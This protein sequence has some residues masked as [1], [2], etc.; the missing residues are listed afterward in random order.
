MDILKSKYYDI[1]TNDKNVCKTEYRNLCKKYHPDVSSAKNSKEIFQHITSL[2]DEAMKKIDSNNWESNNQFEFLTDKSKI[3]VNFLIKIETELCTKYICKNSILYFFEK[4]NKL[5]F[6][7]MI[8]KIK[9]IE[10]YFLLNKELA[11]QYESYFPKILDI[12]ENQDFNIVAIK[13][14]NNSIDLKTLVSKNIPIEPPHV[15]W[16]ISRL[17]GLQMVLA[18]MGIEYNDFSINSIY[19]DVK[20]HDVFLYDGFWYSTKLNEKLIALEKSVYES[21]TLIDKTNKTSS[22]SSNIESI[23]QIG[24]ILLTNGNPNGF[25]YINIPKEIKK[26]FMKGSSND[27]LKEFQ[28]WDKSIDSIGKRVFVKFNVDVENIYEGE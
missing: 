24:K 15:Y 8:E 12:W 6:L 26:F 13:K 11:T 25:E 2:Y 3:K 21:F 28:S 27:S 20:N 18:S 7:N 5:F 23:K 14:D 10:S 22:I 4:K 16:I 19:V 1:F 9:F 17:F